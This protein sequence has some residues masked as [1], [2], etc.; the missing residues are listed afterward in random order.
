MLRTLCVNRIWHLQA[1]MLAASADGVAAIQLLLKHG[2][3]I[4]LQVHTGHCLLT[5]QDTLP[6]QHCVSVRNVRNKQ[7]C[8][9]WPENALA[10]LAAECLPIRD[11]CT[12]QHPANCLRMCCC[13]TIVPCYL[14]IVLQSFVTSYSP[15]IACTHASSHYQSCP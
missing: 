14:S 2:A 4:E 5:A 10:S 6:K 9:L 15:D 11:V 12:E 1:L 8:C 3:T 7:R 13:R